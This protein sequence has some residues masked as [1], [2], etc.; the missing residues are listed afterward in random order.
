[1]ALRVTGGQWE[2]IQ[3]QV[4]FGAGLSWENEIKVSRASQV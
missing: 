3:S 2:V 1:M 4:V